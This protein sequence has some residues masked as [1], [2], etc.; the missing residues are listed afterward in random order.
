MVYVVRKRCL[1]RAGERLFGLRGLTG[2]NR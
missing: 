1:F 2:L